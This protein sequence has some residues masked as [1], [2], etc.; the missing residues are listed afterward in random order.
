MAP[1]SGCNTRGCM[2]K[3]CQLAKT[4]KTLMHNKFNLLSYICCYKISCKLIKGDS[5]LSWMIF[6]WTSSTVG[7][8]S[9]SSW[10]SSEVPLLSFRVHGNNFWATPLL[11]ILGMEI[12]V[13]RI[14]FLLSSTIA[15]MS[16][17]ICYQASLYVIYIAKIL[18]QLLLLI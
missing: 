17:A 1:I 3:I 6:G 12:E 18:F 11:I 15:S 13:H 10:N 7:V 2:R 14:I 9:K 8:A 16:P 4:C 5:T